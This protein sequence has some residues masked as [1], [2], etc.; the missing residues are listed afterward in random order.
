VMI[1]KLLSTAKVDH[2]RPAL[3]RGKQYARHLLA[4]TR[5][6]RRIGSRLTRGLLPR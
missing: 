6:A 5:H 4:R 3:R 1:A 2:D